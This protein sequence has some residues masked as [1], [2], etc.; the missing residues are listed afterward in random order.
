MRW[1]A[2]LP[3]NIQKAQAD[4]MLHGKENDKNA[5]EMTEHRLKITR[6]RLK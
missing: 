2:E 3:E 5:A 4:R 1:T 6:T